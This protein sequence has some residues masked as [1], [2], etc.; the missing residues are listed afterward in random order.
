[1]SFK[2]FSQNSAQAN[3]DTKNVEQTLP[4]DA[5]QATPGATPPN[6]NQDNK[7]VKQPDTN[8]PK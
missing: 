6:P 8:K 3:S 4:K 2:S 1:M 7:E 5:P